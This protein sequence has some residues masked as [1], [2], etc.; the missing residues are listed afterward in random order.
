M[1]ITPAASTEDQDSPGAG[2]YNEGCAKNRTRGTEQVHGSVATQASNQTGC[3]T[4]NAVGDVEK[5]DECTH[6]A[7]PVGRQN[8]L[9]RLDTERREDQCAAE[10]RDQ[11]SAKCDSFI[12]APQINAWP[13]ASMPRDQNATR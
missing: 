8:P 1:K 2:G 5:G 4:C 6:R 3:G 11:G 9:E 10:S 13:I 12:R 7:T